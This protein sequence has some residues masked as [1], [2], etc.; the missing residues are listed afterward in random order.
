MRW[1]SQLTDLEKW[2][3]INIACAGAKKHLK[4]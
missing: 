1:K 4:Q 3:G 2:L